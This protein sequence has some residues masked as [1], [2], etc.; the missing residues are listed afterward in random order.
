VLG[1]QDVGVDGERVRLTGSFDGAFQGVLGFRGFEEEETAVTP[2][3]DEVELACVLSPLQAFGH[4][5]DFSPCEGER[6]ELRSNAH[7]CRDKTAP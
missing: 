4:G 2:E 3:V 6:F 1:H 5:V 7:S